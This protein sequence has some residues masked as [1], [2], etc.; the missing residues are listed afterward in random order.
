M[1]KLE[2]LMREL[3][4]MKQHNSGGLPALVSK[5]RDIVEELAR[6]EIAKEHPCV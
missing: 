2:Q 4:E 3:I 1:S 6:R 5:L